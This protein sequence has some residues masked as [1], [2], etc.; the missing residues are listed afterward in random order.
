MTEWIP[1]VA[2]MTEE[3]DAILQLVKLCKRYQ[4][5]A[6][7][8]MAALEL[9]APTIPGPVGQVLDLKQQLLEN[10]E[11][12]VEIEYRAIESALVRG[13]D[14]LSELLPL[15]DRHRPRNKS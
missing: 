9:L 10:S 2:V 5:Q 11:E 12:E 8:T 14:Y 15:L 3:R 13:T 7:T 4:V 1:P 6:R